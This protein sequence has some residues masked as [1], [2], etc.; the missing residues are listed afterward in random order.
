MNDVL[1]Q[2]FRDVL[3]KERT[4]TRCA[5]LDELLEIQEEKRALLSRI[6]DIGIHDSE[7]EEISELSRRNIGL[8]RHLVSCL[9]GL[10]TGGEEPSIAYS[11]SGKPKDLQ[12]GLRRGAI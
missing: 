2:K 4:A 11:A 12:S 5:N 8:M 3:T 9:R 10:A 6:Q 1:I 7:L